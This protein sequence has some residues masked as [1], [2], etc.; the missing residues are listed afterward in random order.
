M[1]TE[2]LSVEKVD[3]M[4]IVRNETL[5]EPL[6]VNDDFIVVQAGGERF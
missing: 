1:E 4:T 3:R 6:Q 5:D 2:S